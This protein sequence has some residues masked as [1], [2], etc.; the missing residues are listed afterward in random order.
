[1]NCVNNQSELTRLPFAFELVFCGCLVT[2]GS[3]MANISILC[4][5][6]L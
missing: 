4:A 1:M 5:T 3:L 6:N 2:R